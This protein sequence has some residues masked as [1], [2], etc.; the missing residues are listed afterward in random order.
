VSGK[1]LKARQLA[2]EMEE[3][4]KKTAEKKK[5]AKNKK[6]QTKES[7]E[8]V[9]SLNIEIDLEDLEEKFQEGKEE[10]DKKNFEKSYD[11]F[12]EVIEEIHERS[13]AKH[14]EI[15]DPIEELLKQAGKD[16]D[17]ESL[18]EKID[19]SK[20]LLQDEKLHE[21][22]EKALDIEDEAERLLDKKLHEELEKLK[23]IL[24]MLDE[25]VDTKEK[26]SE[27]ISKVEYSLEADDYKRT[28]SLIED[29]KEIFG[30][31]VEN[32]LN[33][34]I[35]TLRER[36]KQLEDQG[37]D[38]Q[39]TEEWLENAESK[40]EEGLYIDV[41]KFL[42]KSEEE[43]N[44]LYGEEILRDKFN[45][46]AFEIS[47]AEDIGAPTKTVKKIRQEAE[48]FRDE[49]K[50]EK[51]E[52][53]LK[54]ALKEIEEV[55]F[56]KVLNT[57][58]ESREDFIKAKEMGAEIEKPMELLKKARNSLKDDNYKE[59]LDWARKGREEVQDLTKKFEKAEEDIEKKREDLNGLKE[60][61][62]EDFSDLE[63]L[64]DK[65]KM[66]L[67]E[68]RTDEAISILEQVDNKIESEVSEEISNLIDEFQ[69]LNQAAE[70]LGI[71]IKEFSK[72]KEELERKLDNSEYIETAKTVQSGKNKVKLKIEDVFEDRI[73]K[74]KE[75]LTDFKDLD[76]KLKEDIDELTEEGME[77]IN[78][79]FHIQAVERIKEAEKTLEEAKKETIENFSEK[80]SQFL[81]K[82]G[83]MD[84]DSIDLDSYRE[85]I[86]EAKDSLNEEMYSKALD[87]LDTVLSEFSQEIY[88]EAE[89]EMRKAE[90]TGIG[91][92]SLKKE[93][94]N[95]KDNL[96]EEDYTLS[97]QSSIN[98]MNEAEEKRKKRK[99]AYEKIYDGSTKMSKLKEQDDL[100]EEDS[101][102][103][104]L[105]N[106]KKQ[107]KQESYS[108]AIREA[109]EALE[110]LENLESRERFFDKM[111]E[112]E[113]NFLK[114]KNI[115][116]VDE[117]I[118]KFDPEIEKIERMSEEI[119]IVGA[120]DKLKE[121]YDELN[122]LLQGI[123]KEKRDEIE[124]LIEDFEAMGQEV[125]E[126]KDQL[127][128][129]NML[130]E[131][132][133]SLDALIFLD[134]IREELKDIGERGQIA[135]EKIEEVKVLSKKAEVMGASTSG[136]ERLI[137]EAQQKLDED[138][139]K[140]SLKKAK[141]AENKIRKA[142]KKRVESI[143]G[144]FNQKIEK[145]KS[146]GVDTA[147][148]EDKIQKAK[149]ARDNG[150]YIEA[151]KFSMESERELDKINN[152]KIIAGNIISR[153]EKMLKEAQ[154]KGL[155]IDE[156][157]DIFRESEQAFENG[158]YPKAI[159]LSIATTENLSKIL[160]HYD[161][162]GSFL[163]NLNSII[164][165]LRE[166][167]KN[168]SMLFEEK[169]KIE[170]NYKD[171]N[172]QQGIQHM[173]NVEEIL[174]DNETGLRNI[175]SELET[176]VE[177]R[178]IKNIEK[179]IE[180]LEKAKFLIEMKNPFKA[181]KNIEKAK[182]LSGLEK[183]KKYYD[184]ME[185]VKESLK[186]A[187]KF[188]ASVEKVENKVQEA[189]D[190]ESTGEIDKA[191]DKIKQA[192]SMVEE[193]L[194]DYSPKLKV[195]VSKTLIINEWND[196]KIHLI[197]EGE[198]L[199]KNLQIE[200][201][202]G[203]VRDFTRGERLKAGEEKEVDVEIKP[204]KEKAQII[205][206]VLR[207]FDNEVLEDEEDLKVSQGSKIKEIERDGICDHCGNKIK[208]KENIILCSCGN[209]YEISC[210]EEISECPNCGT[211]LKTEEK[212]RKKEKRKRVSLD[213]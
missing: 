117:E 40:I 122:V 134:E 76:T 177:E 192:N 125:D 133:K 109:E 201:R 160:Q 23:S 60:I 140:E 141:S 164:D 52:S 17:L 99:E 212:E 90:K 179:S 118:K 49:N 30:D 186:N 74:I 132:K 169:K 85:R 148:A 124:N 190:N 195:K 204:E 193:I 188:G 153:T 44:P 178:G 145:L 171:G 59:A 101:I 27:L 113:D 173:E 19:E 126:Y 33:E 116:L 87:I 123:L 61:L 162:L 86:Y 39:K 12:E 183:Q 135:R 119:G 56:D 2:K 138:K 8:I 203:E 131:E 102:R 62:D 129:T 93:L 207:I 54:D 163:E 127:E 11:L 152:Q 84:K 16:I 155:F 48:E 197:N 3:K 77:K 151:I 198:A 9:K 159:E 170:E 137:Q 150:D 68:K 111:K 75:S 31:E 58:A 167:S 110:K 26:G 5:E 37:I 189:K 158:F 6:E 98:V 46:L 29:T 20:N 206:R 136:L 199:G 83:E 36:K 50:I 120:R 184:L 88:K 147:L 91:V 57:I 38:V 108:N 21:A 194:E 121:K 92:E 28:L 73:Q 180:K 78:E 114:A 146:R 67:E 205:A 71:D 165:D 142:Q 65:S 97:I 181:L 24:D 115:D 128:K 161:N 66:K 105:K 208:K 41:L 45:E 13:L 106:A 80:T 63:D 82:I 51:S 55:K 69:G 15:L 143:L 47:E 64:I 1:Y 112:L 81:S 14:D 154:N 149:K 168:F 200:I 187:K 43:I 185:H 95:S 104:L 32:S 196:V 10:L 176:E 202:G 7:L 35:K 18:E 94:K 130:I 182:E 22:F 34:K 53:R 174:I 213:I 172:Y 96:E 79:G 157:L 103:G 25:S 191:Y 4:A 175:I 156:V 144:N 70:D 42:K 166:S 89:K 139:Y 107:F 209:T 72:Q 210:G 211:P 100:D